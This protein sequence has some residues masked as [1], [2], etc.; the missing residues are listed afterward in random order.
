MDIISKAMDAQKSCFDER[1]ALIEK[2]V[3]L[4][5][6]LQSANQDVLKWIHSTADAIE[7][8]ESYKIR[9]AEYGRMFT[10]TL[11]YRVKAAARVI[12]GVPYLNDVQKK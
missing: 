11:P 6:R 1:D 7:E 10:G 2:V 9:L 4:E 8:R 12:M 3:E 5:V